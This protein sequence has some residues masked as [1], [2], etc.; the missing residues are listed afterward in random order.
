MR[1]MQG[2]GAMRAAVRLSERLTG[3]ILVVLGLGALA[4]DRPFAS[5]MTAAAAVALVIGFLMAALGS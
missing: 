4:L 1:R 5:A 3:V 2:H